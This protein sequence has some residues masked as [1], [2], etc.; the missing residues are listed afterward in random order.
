LHRPGVGIGISVDGIDHYHDQQRV[1]KKSGRGSWSS[2]VQNIAVLKADGIR[3]YIMATTTTESAPGLPRLAEW[4]FSE[5]LATRL[6]V[7]R[8]HEDEDID[9]ETKKAGYRELVEACIP[10]FENVFAYVERHHDTIDVAR[11]LNI[12]EL[13]FDNPLSGPACGIGRNH[14]VYGHTGLLADCVMTM[15]AAQTEATENLLQDVQKTV[16]HMPFDAGSVDG[17]SDCLRCQWFTV[18]GGGC[19][20]GNER[21]NGHPYTRSPLCE[22]YKYVIPRY[23]IC[24]SENIVARAQMPC[25]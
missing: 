6:N 18:C 4:I 3:P 7:V 22:F 25:A 23:L 17:Q 15:H 24:L 12:C 14:I 10:S 13:S 11:Q 21:V 19:P 2:I 5:G 16:R 9:L 1:F 8:G 20:T